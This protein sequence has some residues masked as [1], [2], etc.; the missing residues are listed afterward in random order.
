M[1][2]QGSDVYY[3]PARSVRGRCDGD[4]VNDVDGYLLIDSPFHDGDRWP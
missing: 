4:D 1:K 2:C 3:F